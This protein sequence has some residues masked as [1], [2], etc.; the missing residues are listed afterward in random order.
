MREASVHT[1]L[2]RQILLLIFLSV[3]PGLAY[4]FLGWMHDIVMPALIWYGFVLAVSFYGYRLHRRFFDRVYMAEHG[5]TWYRFLSYYFYAF[6]GLWTAIFLLYVSEDQYNLHYIAIFTQI[7]AATVASTLLVSDRRL[8]IPVLLYLMLP[9]TLYFGM[10]G[11]WYGYILMIFSLIFTGVLFYSSES[12]YTL[13]QKSI[14]QGTHDQLTGLFNRHYFIGHLQERIE[15]IKGNGLCTYMLLIDLDH[16]KTINDSLG[17]DIG[18]RLLEEVTARMLEVAG[19]DHVVARLGGDEF[20]VIGSNAREQK[21]CIEKASTLADTL[22]ETL[23][24]HYVIER[25]HLYIS[26]SI[27]ISLLDDRSINANSFLKEADIAMYEAKAQGRD[28]AFVFDDRMA[29]RIE[30]NLELERLLHFALS[31]NEIYLVYQPQINREHQV[32]GCEVLVRWNS[33]ALGEVKPEEFIPIAEQTGI[34][35]EIGRFV[36]EEA[37]KTLQSWDAK[38]IALNQFS[39]NISMRQFFYYHFVDEIEELCAT[40]LNKTLREKVMFELTESVMAE[41]FKRVISVMQS[42]KA[43]GIQFSMDDFGTGYSSLSYIKKMPIDEIKID[44]SFIKELSDDM[45]DQEMIITI[46]HMA[47]IFNLNIVAEGVETE[48]QAAFLKENECDILQG[49]LFSKP[50]EKDE[51]EAFYQALHLI[52]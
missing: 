19:S 36:L 40:Y 1:F 29:E 32:V 50:L 17:H 45:S 8:Y 5:E 13:L 27:G 10:I 44:R 41:D 4:I 25:H 22:L 24:Q 26:A 2:H 37:F 14:Y 48:A 16:F 15:M 33:E 39:I 21:R 30:R 28:G 46:L 31:R 49:Y 9:L 42:L 47:K 43:N 18:D 51:F 7:G 52:D 6:F 34:I 23:K 11:E 35:V 12:S 3:G 20:I 38:A